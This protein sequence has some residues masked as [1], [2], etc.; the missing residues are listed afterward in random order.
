MISKLTEE[1]TLALEQNQQL[2]Q[3]LVL[4]FL[5]ILCYQ[6]AVTHVVRFLFL[7][8]QKILIC[9]ACVQNIFW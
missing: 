2:H 9:I 7:V 5:G 8:L 1:K 3:E 6:L 4:V